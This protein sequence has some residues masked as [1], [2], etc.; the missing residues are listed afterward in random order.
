MHNIISSLP[1]G[2]LYA[3]VDRV[4][5]SA[6]ERNGFE[7]CSWFGLTSIPGRAWGLQLLLECGAVYSTVPPHALAFSE[8]PEPNWTLQQAQRWDLPGDHFGCHVYEQLAR[9]DV[10]AYVRGAW[11]PASYLFTARHSGDAYSQEPEQA[12]EYHF[13][14]TDH[15]RLTILPG[16][17]ML[18]HDPAFTIVRGKPDW[19]R[20]QTEVYACESVEPWDRTIGEHT[21]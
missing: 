7:R 14:R 12:K 1:S 19:L 3:F 6:G 11:L 15:D 13:L 5:L 2:H 9:R 8:Q 21:A 18:V 10:E 4:V 20:V 17:C 16:N